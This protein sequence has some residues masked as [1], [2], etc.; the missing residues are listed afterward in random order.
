MTVTVH[1][2]V[3]VLV[4]VLDDHLLR[5]VVSNLRP[6]SSRTFTHQRPPALQSH[7][8]S[9]SNDRVE[10]VG[11]ENDQRRSDHSAHE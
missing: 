5:F 6:Q 9:V 7:V 8:A 3:I 4:F 10:N 1:A 11:T 2:A